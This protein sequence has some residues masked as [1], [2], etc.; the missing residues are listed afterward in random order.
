MDSSSLSDFLYTA[1]PPEDS[2]PSTSSSCSRSLYEASKLKSTVAS[3]FNQF[4]PVR[5]W[6]DDLSLETDTECGVTLQS[7]VLPKRKL[8][9]S[10][11]ED[12]QTRDLKIMTASATTAA[13]KLLMRVERFDQHYQ[14][15]FE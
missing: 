11:N 3:N 10:K 2:V 4:A 5:A 13:T 8:Q 1:E 6:L 12:S 14:N 9:D 15:V 7:K